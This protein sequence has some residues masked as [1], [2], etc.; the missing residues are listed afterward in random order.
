M[1]SWIRLL[2]HGDPRL[3]PRYVGVQCHRHG[4]VL[5]L[6][7]DLFKWDL[8][9]NPHIETVSHLPCPDTLEG[10]LFHHRG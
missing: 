8:L 1:F 2:S 5:D 7:Q 3:A 9:S 6:L 10:L 4:L